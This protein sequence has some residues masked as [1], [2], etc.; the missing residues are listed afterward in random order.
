MRSCRHKKGIEMSLNTFIITHHVGELDDFD[1]YDGME[2]DC[3]RVA[4][5]VGTYSTAINK[6]YS[7]W[8]CECELDFFRGWLSKNH[9]RRTSLELKY[10]VHMAEQALVKKPVA[11]YRPAT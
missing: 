7:V 9:K 4:R 2:R 10:D 3:S 11:P 8:R 6:V 1:F 5:H